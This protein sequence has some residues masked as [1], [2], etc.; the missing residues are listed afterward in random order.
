MT[1]KKAADSFKNILVNFKFRDEI[2]QYCT[3]LDD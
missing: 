2:R 3:V 1:E